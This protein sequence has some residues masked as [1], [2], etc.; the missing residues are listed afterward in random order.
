[1][2][3]HHDMMHRMWT[4]GLYVRFM[5]A[6]R[7]EVI[8]PVGVYRETCHWSRDEAKGGYEKGEKDD[9]VETYC[10]PAHGV[11]GW[12]ECVICLTD[13]ILSN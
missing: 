3:M 1:M 13:M 2:D 8:D 6:F 4:I 9:T 7:K 5:E 10:K 11:S 12:E